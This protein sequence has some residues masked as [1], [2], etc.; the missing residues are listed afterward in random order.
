M[1]GRYVEE[2]VLED[3]RFHQDTVARQANSP[4]HLIREKEMEISGQVLAAKKEA[5]DIVA[6]ARKKAVELKNRAEDEADK[7]AAE[8]EKK[9]L[10]EV[11]REIAQLDVSTGEEIETL[12]GL[13]KDR[14]A[15]AV[16][17]VAERVTSV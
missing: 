10:A 6:A 7:L 4:L 11:D 17:F 14:T 9:V 5:E 8:H 13:I 15:S 3:I 2:K 16:T 12:K 1:E